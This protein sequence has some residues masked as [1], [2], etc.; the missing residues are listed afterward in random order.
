[1]AYRLTNVY[2]SLERFCGGTFQA[3]NEKLNQNNNKM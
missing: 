1:M 2:N 3:E